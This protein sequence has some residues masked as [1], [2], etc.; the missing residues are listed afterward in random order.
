MAKV[1]RIDTVL[2]D[3]QEKILQ[4]LM[5]QKMIDR[6]SVVKLAIKEMYD[7]ECGRKKSGA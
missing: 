2:T 6:N 4:Q 3:E 5:K 1:N 7:R